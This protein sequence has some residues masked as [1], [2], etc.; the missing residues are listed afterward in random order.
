MPDG[1]QIAD[2]LYSFK[3][4]HIVGVFKADYAESSGYTHGYRVVEACVH[5]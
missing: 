2:R 3:V 4:G 5:K 1:N